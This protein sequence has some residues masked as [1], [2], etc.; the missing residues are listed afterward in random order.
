MWQ[1][2]YTDASDIWNYAT[3]EPPPQ[4]LQWGTGELM[5][6]SGELSSP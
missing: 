1:E 5:S 2:I 4:F 3:L 6:L